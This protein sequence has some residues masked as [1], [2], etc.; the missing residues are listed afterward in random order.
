MTFDELHT[1]A[2]QKG[3][4]YYIDP[5]TGYSV[6]TAVELRRRGACCGSGCRH[7]PFD[8]EAVPAEKKAK[9]RAKRLFR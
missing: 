2:C 3:L 9:I 5:L 8:H 1:Q 4:S 6:M 7:C